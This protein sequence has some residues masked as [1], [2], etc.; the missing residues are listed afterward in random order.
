MPYRQKS[1]EIKGVPVGLTTNMLGAF[2]K[3]NLITGYLWGARNVIWVMK[4]SRLA[5][6]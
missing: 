1:S 4:D 2:V 3:Y 6:D 5:P